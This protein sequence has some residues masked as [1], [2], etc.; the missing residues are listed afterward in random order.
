MNHDSRPQIG[1]VRTVGML[2][3]QMVE[4]AQMHTVGIG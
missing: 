3:T 2:A 4:E 1:G